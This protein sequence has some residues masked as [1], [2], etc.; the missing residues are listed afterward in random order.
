MEF[1]LE[2]NA[3][4][5]AT[6]RIIA[7]DPGSETSLAAVHDLRQFYRETGQLEAMSKNGWKHI[8]SVRGPALKV[9]EILDPELLRNK[10]RVYA[11]LDAHP[12]FLTYDRRA[13]M[14]KRPFHGFGEG[15]I[16][17]KSEDSAAPAVQP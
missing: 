12:R 10:K 5:E 7:K 6:D 16:N 3:V 15:T 11:W 1:F 4:N 9:A 14:A 13:A 8:A 17:G 2:K